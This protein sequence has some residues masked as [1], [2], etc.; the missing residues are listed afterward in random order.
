MPLTIEPH[1][2]TSHASSSHRCFSQTVTSHVLHRRS[3]RLRLI[4]DD[5]ERSAL[6]RLERDDV[7]GRGAEIRFGRPLEQLHD[8]QASL[9]HTA[10]DLRWQAYLCTQWAEQIALAER[11][12]RPSNTA[13][14][15]DCFAS[16]DG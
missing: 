7:A 8:D 1:T 3:R 15:V 10:E 5:L 2:F 6:L 12:V 13:Q 9:H 16:F 14:T 4:A 11:T